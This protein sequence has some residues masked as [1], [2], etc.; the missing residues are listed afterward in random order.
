MNL[1]P[2]PRHAGSVSL[3][4]KLQTAMVSPKLNINDGYL[5]KN[6]AQQRAKHLPTPT[7]RPSQDQGST[8]SLSEVPSMHHLSEMSVLR[9]SSPGRCRNHRLMIRRKNDY[10]WRK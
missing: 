2:S 7:D 6:S 8:I 9:P 4:L 5:F 3:I 10:L 1:G